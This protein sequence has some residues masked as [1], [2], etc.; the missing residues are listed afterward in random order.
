MS[1]L[2]QKQTCA[3]QERNVRFVPIA[4]MVTRRA[5][6]RRLNPFRSEHRT[7]CL[8][9]KC[10]LRH[11]A[12]C[13][14]RHDAARTQLPL[15]SGA[16]QRARKVRRSAGLIVG[17]TNETHRRND[18]DPQDRMVP[19]VVSS[20]ASRRPSCQAPQSRTFA[21]NCWPSSTR[22]K[23]RT[24]EQIRIRAA[25]ISNP[26]LSRNCERAD[27]PRNKSC[28]SSKTLLK[29]LPQTR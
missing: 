12:L 9:E 23:G 4:G 16:Y 29:T 25:T 22:R 27:C 8:I 15:C 18:R 6:R 13:R 1:A 14:V 7:N 19:A 2:G 11:G 20:P 28:Q 21:G 10:C 24:D 26:A 5:F 17:S 3:V